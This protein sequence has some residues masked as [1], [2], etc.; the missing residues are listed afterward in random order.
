[1]LDYQIGIRSSPGQLSLHSGPASFS[2]QQRAATVSIE[3]E[4]QPFSIANGLSTLSIDSTACREETGYYQP[5]S[6]AH[7]LWQETAQ[8]SAANIAQIV[9]TGDALT[10]SAQRGHGVPREPA[11]NPPRDWTIDSLPH[12]L[13]AIRI[14]PGQTT[15]SIG[16]LPARIQISP[17]PPI[18][19]VQAQPVAVDYQ[20]GALDIYVR[21]TAGP[22]GGLLDTTG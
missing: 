7:H 6:Y 2:V 14:T 16:Y 21:P 20:P 17:Q 3:H 13:P 15:V 22:L 10:A 18:V 4:H 5:V 1:V 8:I 12:S 11:G 19:R 9:Q